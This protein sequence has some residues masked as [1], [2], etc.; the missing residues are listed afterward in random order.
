ME[1]T[2][3]ERSSEEI[4]QLIKEDWKE[5]ILEAGNRPPHPD[6]FTV[7]FNDIRVDVTMPDKLV[8]TLPGAPTHAHFTL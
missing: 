7:Y 3:T 8:V 1:I 6:K 2:V 5:A 4:L